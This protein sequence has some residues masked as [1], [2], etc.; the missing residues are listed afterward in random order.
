[1]ADRFHRFLSLSPKQVEFAFKLAAEMLFPAPVEAHVPAPEG[2]V[3]FQG[4]V[5]SLKLVESDFGL[6]T[7]VTVK[8]AA[9]NGVWLA[10]GT[11]PS[12]LSGVQ[13]GDTV[14]L[15]AALA[16][17]RDAHFAFFKRPTKGEVIESVAAQ[18][19]EKLAA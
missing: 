5:V 10:W 3:R 12:S 13:R 8:V 18:Q 9:E 4:T 14:A 1:M 15:T 2:R 11:L 19:D 6:T 17:G 7:K 16:R